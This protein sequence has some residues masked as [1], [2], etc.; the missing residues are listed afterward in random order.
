M[1]P[2]Y[3][4][5]VLAVA[6]SGLVLT[7]LFV[8][9]P[10]T[11]FGSGSALMRYDDRTNGY[12]WTVRHGWL[13][14]EVVLWPLSDEFKDP[15]TSDP[16]IQQVPRSV[17]KDLSIYPKATRFYLYGFPFF[18]ASTVIADDR[19]RDASAIFS[20]PSILVGCAY[21][22]VNVSTD[23][24]SVQVLPE[25]ISPTAFGLSWLVNSSA[26]FMIQ[27]LS[28]S[29][30]RRVRRAVKASI[31]PGTVACPACKYNAIG[32]SRCPECGTTIANLVQANNQSAFKE[33]NE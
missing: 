12:S 13:V 26:C 31:H 6:I 15:F 29:L 18:W 2:R 9:P 20:R 17:L 27:W 21:S 25:L 23:I 10:F 11:S 8:V 30:L 5:K 7:L 22:D 32:L 3:S 24:N 1:G 33:T 16:P 19:S 4:R 14:T 28:F